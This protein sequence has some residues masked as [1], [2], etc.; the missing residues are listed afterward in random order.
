MILCKL[1]YLIYRNAEMIQPFSCD[2]FTCTFFHR[3]LD[4]ITCYICKETVYP[5]ADFIF[6]LLLKL[7]LSINSPAQ[8]PS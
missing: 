4:I 3:L 6:L 5:Y 2:F 1:V 7:S 8:K